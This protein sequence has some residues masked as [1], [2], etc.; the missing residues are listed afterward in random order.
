MTAEG[1]ALYYTFR[2]LAH[3]QRRV[4]Q[5]V[6]SSPHAKAKQAERDAC[7]CIYSGQSDAGHLKVL[8][9]SPPILMCFAI[10]TQ[11][12]RLDSYPQD[13]VGQIKEKTRA[14]GKAKRRKK[15][16]CRKDRIN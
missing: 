1:D 15:K 2:I 12:S 9:T 11:L 4:Y 6:P 5:T 14:K 7:T 8:R 3:F 16:I 10:S 13:A